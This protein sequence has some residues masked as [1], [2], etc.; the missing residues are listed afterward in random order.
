[1]LI[2]TGAAGFIGSCLVAHLNKLGENKL[3]LVDNFSR[4]NKYKN[5]LG[6][7]FLFQIERTE[8][9]DWL[10]R[11][12][13][14]IRGIF[15]LGAKTDTLSKEQA[16]FDALNFNY[17]KALWKICTSKGIPLIYASS[18]ATYGN[19]D[20]GFDDKKTIKSLQPQNTYAWSKQSF[21]LWVEQQEQQ[22]PFWAGIKFFNV[23]GPNEYHKARMASVVFHAFH[24]IK[25][26]GRMKLFRSHKSGIADGEQKRDFIYVKDICK[27]CWY[28][29]SNNCANGLYNAGTGTGRTFNDLVAAIFAALDLPQKVE[30][31]DT[32]QN[33]R[34]HY[35]YFTE[36]Q[37]DK[38]VATGFSNKLRPIEE[39]VIEYVRSYLLENKYY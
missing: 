15:H 1:M 34:E 28:L 39:G 13:H 38:L 8:F 12:E 33:I 26:T 25:T 5:Y 22:P 9:I 20:L 14:S 21:D 11:T 7:E 31:I 36:A 2:V 27:I 32:P 30:F 3:V 37:M 24:Q 10:D 35:Q 23:Y 4:R 19:G 6:K 17:S 16:V 18:A 29:F